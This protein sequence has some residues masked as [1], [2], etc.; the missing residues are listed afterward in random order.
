M[1][2]RHQYHPICI[3]FSFVPSLAVFLD[4]FNHHCLKVYV[5][6]C[7]CFLLSCSLSIHSRCEPHLLFGALSFLLWSDVVACSLAS[8]VGACTSPWFYF[9]FCGQVQ[10]L[11]RLLTRIKHLTKPWYIH[12]IVLCIATYTEN[13]TCSAHSLPEDASLSL[14]AL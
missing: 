2:S 3:L 13:I 12:Q 4:I 7:C 14:P 1:Q 5:F 6:F 11:E 9:S 8:W 10:H